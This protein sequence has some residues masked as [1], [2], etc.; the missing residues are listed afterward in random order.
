MVKIFG[1]T[2]EEVA[3]SIKKADLE[4]ITREFVKDEDTCVTSEGITLHNNS[5]VVI[6]S[7]NRVYVSTPQKIDLAID[8]ASAYEKR[9]NEEFTV[10][11]DYSFN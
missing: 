5:V 9:C 3:L 2:P 4:Q 8:L 7:I 10:K 1:R 6:P 11:K